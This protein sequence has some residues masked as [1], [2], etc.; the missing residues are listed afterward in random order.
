MRIQFDSASP[1]PIE[2]AAL[3]ARHRMV[4][5]QQWQER[6]TALRAGY[7]PG[8]LY[9]YFHSKDAILSAL[10]GRVIE[11][12]VGGVRAIRPPKPARSSMETSARVAP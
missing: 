2:P 12:L 7:T 6:V 3:A 10:R 4:E 11:R 1:L 8:A 5:R 9:A